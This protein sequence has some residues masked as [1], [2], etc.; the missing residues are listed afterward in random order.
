[1]EE[2]KQFEDWQLRIREEREEMLKKAT[3]LRNFIDN[4]ESKANYREWAM[5]R[6]QLNAMR[7]YLCILTERCK[8]YELIEPSTQD[9]LDTFYR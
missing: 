6:R 4:P 5:M 7:E 8:Y 1:M 2:K 3:K 9:I